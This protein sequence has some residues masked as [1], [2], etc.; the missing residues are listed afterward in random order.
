M[1]CLLSPLPF[2]QIR[3][4]SVEMAGCGLGQYKAGL[5]WANRIS[6]MRTCAGTYTHAH[7]HTHTLI[8]GCRLDL[9]LLGVWPFLL[10]CFSHWFKLTWT[11]AFFPNFC[12]QGSILWYLLQ[13]Q[14]P[15][16]GLVRILP[17]KQTPEGFTS[18]RASHRLTNG[19][20][21]D[22]CTTNS[23][24]GSLLT[25]CNSVLNSRATRSVDTQFNFKVNLH[26]LYLPHRKERSIENEI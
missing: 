9:I 10:L 15:F 13:Y 20:S 23:N 18:L 6:Q 19:H 12:S 1:L 25:P 16:L 8:C 14:F 3:G 4:V 24:G 21:G 26:V 5:T 7:T 2:S 22:H 11:F 17:D